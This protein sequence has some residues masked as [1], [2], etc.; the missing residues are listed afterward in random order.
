MVG[1]CLLFDVLGHSL[2]L[3]GESGW[4]ATALAELAKIQQL[5]ALGAER[6]ADL[7]DKWVVAR[8]IGIGS[9]PMGD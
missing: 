1:C 7:P 5:S 6:N 2:A 9:I 4:T 3:P 8:C